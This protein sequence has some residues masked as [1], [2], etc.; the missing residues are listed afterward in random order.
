MKDYEAEELL[1]GRTNSKFFWI[2]L[3]VLAVMFIVSLLFLRGCNNATQQVADIKSGVEIRYAPPAQSVDA[4]GRNHAEKQVIEGSK[5]TVSFIYKDKYDSVCNIV[6]IQKRQI[7]ALTF[8]TSISEGKVP[9]E[10]KNTGTDSAAFSY[11]D[12]WLEVSGNTGLNPVMNYKITDSISFV[13]YWKRPWFLG[14]KTTYVNVFSENKNLHFVQ[15][16]ATNVR[17]KEPGRFSIGPYFGYGWDGQRWAPSIGA[18][19]Q[20]SIIR[21]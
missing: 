5:E 13:T 4:A 20:Y 12:K 16:E 17:I 9:L 6:G 2:I 10:V 3:C 18:S 11:K 7:R 15:L 19:I 14:R 8:A 1:P 21:F